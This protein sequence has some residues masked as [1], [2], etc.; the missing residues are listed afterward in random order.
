[1]GV[2]FYKPSDLVIEEYVETDGEKALMAGI[3]YYDTLCDAINESLRSM[4]NDKLSRVVV[5]KVNKDN[6]EQ[7]KQLV[8]VAKVLID[9]GWI[10]ERD[11]QGSNI[12]LIVYNPFI[13]KGNI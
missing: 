7:S 6:V 10:C 1:M 12:V 2:L 11:M 9:D 8:L 5:C 4:I 13:N 3:P